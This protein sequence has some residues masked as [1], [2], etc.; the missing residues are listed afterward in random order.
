MLEAFVIQAEV[1]FGM[2]HGLQGL[3]DKAFNQEL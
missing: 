3:L 2:I 1:K